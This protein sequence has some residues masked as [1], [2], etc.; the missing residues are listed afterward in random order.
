MDSGEKASAHIVQL[1][2]SCLQGRKGKLFFSFDFHSAAFL[3]I[4]PTT[5]EYWSSTSV[6]AKA[7]KSFHFHRVRPIVSAEEL[8]QNYRYNKMT[9]ESVCIH[10][11][12][13]KA[14]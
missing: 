1:K 6:A 11:D 7:C 9:C 10:L 2:I 4:V 13:T 8:V 5:K 12:S 3:N 14:Y